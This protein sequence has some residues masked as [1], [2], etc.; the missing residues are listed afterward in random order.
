MLEL[1]LVIDDQGKNTLVLMGDRLSL[2]FRSAP[3]SA[4]FL[5]A[6]EAFFSAWPAIKAGVPFACFAVID[7]DSG[8]T[9]ENL[10]ERQRTTVGKLLSAPGAAMVTCM[11]GDSVLA[12]A[13]RAMGRMLLIGLR[14]IH[15]AATTEEGAEMISKHLAG[16]VSAAEILKALDTIITDTKA[17]PTWRP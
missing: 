13:N 3:L 4:A 17:L 14:N 15:H 2:Q 9:D 16:Y 10:R 11:P 7:G 12:S 8:V 5:D 6:T 1:Q